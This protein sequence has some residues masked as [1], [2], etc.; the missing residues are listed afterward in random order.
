M[1][2]RD[3]EERARRDEALLIPLPRLGGEGR[4]RGT[5]AFTSRSG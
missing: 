1:G 2:E 4:V 3:R 5:D